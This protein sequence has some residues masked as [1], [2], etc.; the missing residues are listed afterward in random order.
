MRSKAGWCIA[1]VLLGCA[2]TVLLWSITRP[3][4][5]TGTTSSSE[6]LARPASWS[7]VGLGDSI[8]SGDGC[9]SCVPFVDL[10]AREITRATSI[11]MSVTNLGVG[12]STSA[13]LLASLSA[14]QPAASRV[15]SADVITV[16]IGANDFFPQPRRVSGQRGLPSTS[17]RPLTNRIRVRDGARGINRTPEACTAVDWAVTAGRA[18]RRRFVRRAS[19]GRMNH[20]VISGGHR[21]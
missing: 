9:P 17:H 7:L 20:T 14:G 1:V 16:T 21:R 19:A 15:R 11:P 10:Y 4:L 13:D 12:G 5:A 2:V 6:S 18:A 3:S 8:T